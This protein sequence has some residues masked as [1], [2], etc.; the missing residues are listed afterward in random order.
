MTKIRYEYF[1]SDGG[2][3]FY[4]A[5]AIPEVETPHPI[6][7][8]QTEA[9]ERLMQEMAALTADIKLHLETD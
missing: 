4:Q 5:I 7:K 6:H 9:L 3:D 2:H 8:E 1:G